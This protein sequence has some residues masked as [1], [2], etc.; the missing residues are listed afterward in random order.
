MKKILI[1]LMVMLTSITYGQTTIGGTITDENND[2]LPGMI[3]RISETKEGTVTGEDGTFS[4]TT[5]QSFP[6][7]ITISGVGYQQQKFV[8]TNDSGTTLVMKELT[9]TLD[10]VVVSASRVPEKLFESPVSIE[11]YTPEDIANSSS[12][13][14][15]AGLENLKGVDL[16]TGSFTFQSVN[17]RGFATLANNR[18]VQLVDGMDNSSP[19]LNFVLGN[20]LG[21]NE[22]DVERI[23][24]LPGASS[25]LYGA[26]AFNGILFMTSKSP[27]VYQGISAYGKVGM[28]SQEFSANNGFH[29]L[30]VRF[31]NKFSDKFAAKISISQLNGKEWIA[32][33]NRDYIN[34]G[35]RNTNPG[36]DG[37]NIY[38]D[39][40]A[41]TINFREIA[42]AQGLP[43]PLVDQLNL[44]SE[45]ISR[46]GYDERDVMNY[47]ASSLKADIALHYKPKA[48]DL[49]FIFNSRFGNGN[50]IYQGANR[51]SIKDF[52]TYQNKL[53]V[54]ND[55]FFVRGYITNED[56]GDSYD[57]R[58][59]SINTN[60][61]WKSDNDWFTQYVQGYLGAI[62]GQVP[63]SEVGNKS[64]AH[65]IARQFA[66]SGRLIP[67]TAEFN[68]VFG[69]VT[70]DPSLLTGSQFIDK[71]SLK[72][73]DANYNFNRFID[74]ADWQVGGSWRKYAL[75]SEGTIFT[76]YDDKI[77]YNEYGLYTQIQKRLAE[78]KLKFTGSLRYDKN[79]I[80]DG[81]LSPR[82]SA[83]FS[84]DENHNHN[85]RASYQTGFRNPITQD[86]Y[87]GLNIGQALLI[88]SAPDN[89]D[90]Y[91]SD[92]I[93]TSLNGQALGFPQTISLSGRAA[94]ENAFTLNSL[95][96]FGASAAQGNPNPALLKQANIELIKPE[97]ITAYEVGYR[98]ALTKHTF[99]DVSAYFNNYEDFIASETVVVPRYGNVDFS[100]IHPVLQQPNA[101]LAVANGDYT[102][103]QT[104]TNSDAKIDS[105]G[106][107]LG[108]DTKYMN[109][110]LG[111][112]YSW[113]K[114]DFDQSQDPDFEA[115][116]NTPEHKVKAYAGNDNFYKNLGFMVNWR[117]ND[118]YLWQSSFI[119]AMVDNRSIVDA[120]I[121]FHA[122]TLKSDFK[123][124]ASN[125]L[126]Y[127]YESVPGTGTIGA[128]YFLSWTYNNR[129]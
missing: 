39:E 70:S 42:L 72:H 91:Q 93:L 123:L 92:P 12:A 62:T 30:G 7:E 11:Q 111:F 21:M 13:N 19:A 29:D 63:S 65:K 53:E 31:A 117:W 66:D 32:N 84:P 99:L 120:Q 60:R 86:F 20:L 88:G 41:T 38:G 119:D 14:F 18:F 55:N 26:N 76:D 15:Y 49:E 125:I 82:I 104:Y 103:F 71:T 56:A 6:I 100:D 59:A 87:I 98:G 44:G 57:A 79:E 90:R 97:N 34:G 96:A 46:T 113:A 124:G 105:K 110:D 68:R 51:Y 10:Q 28:Q 112:S 54:R 8:Y 74:W 75:N 50:T 16:N 64:L 9:N 61:R 69:E 109:Y 24:L 3:I 52:N 107:N 77:I 67:G 95:R 35:N 128:Q 5:S 102:P 89:L 33:D 48:N 80:L 108:V 116:F 121:S 43:Q 17:T 83:V 101:L 1:A 73:V 47:D 127:K 94:Y 25:A 129:H 27:F 85:F 22:L 23:E 81:F 78:D 45:L 106:I 58:F 126:D 115:G 122:P 40:V 37:L 114:F 36:F 2:A 4:L 118:S